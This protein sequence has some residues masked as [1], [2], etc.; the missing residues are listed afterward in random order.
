VCFVTDSETD[1]FH[2][3]KLQTTRQNRGESPQDF[4]DHCRALVQKIVCKVDD[5]VAQHIH[6]QNA[7]HI[8][9]SA[10]RHSQTGP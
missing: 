5:P 9:A 10:V 4:A 2:Y 1:Q 3:M 7:E 8:S 6:Q